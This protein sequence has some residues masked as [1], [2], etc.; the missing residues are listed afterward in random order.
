MISFAIPGEPNANRRPRARRVG[1][2]VRVHQDPRDLSW[3]GCAQVLMQAAMAGRPPLDVPCELHIRAI[4]ECPASLRR[5]REPRPADWHPC[6]KD[7]DNVAK[8]VMDAGNGVLWTDDHLIVRL[9]VEK[10]RAPQGES[11]RVE[12]IAGPMRQEAAP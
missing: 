12:V 11:S 1:A 2:F 8:S 10:R 4:W 9:T 5:K 6:A 7:A 3:K